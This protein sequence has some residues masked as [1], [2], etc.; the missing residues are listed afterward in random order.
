MCGSCT[1]A[2]SIIGQ[3]CV[4]FCFY[5]F[6]Y[7][8]FPFLVYLFIYLFSFFPLNYLVYLTVASFQGTAQDTMLSWNDTLSLFLALILSLSLSHALCLSIPLFCPLTLA[9]SHSLS[10]SWSCSSCSIL[11]PSLPHFQTP[12]LIPVVMVWYH[13][14]GVW[15]VGC[16]FFWFCFVIIICC[17]LFADLPIDLLY[18]DTHASIPPLPLL[19][20]S[21][22]RG[23]LGFVVTWFRLVLDVLSVGLLSVSTPPSPASVQYAEP[24]QCLCT[25]C[26]L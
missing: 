20:L 23:F 15:R 13:C 4:L 8:Y 26:V 5:A 7:F 12:T 2:E 21:V 3:P 1:L 24:T 10:L 11:W 18:I 19:S 9:L 25:S 14:F 22:V 17:L 6:F 16:S